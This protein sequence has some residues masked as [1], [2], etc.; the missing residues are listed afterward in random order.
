MLRFYGKV[1]QRT[2]TLLWESAKAWDTVAG[3]ATL[4]LLGLGVSVEW[5]PW[6]AVFAPIAL[7][8]FY[9]ALRANYEAFQ[10]I[11]RE[12][13]SLSKN[14]R[15]L[16]EDLRETRQR[17]E[18]QRRRANN[19]DRMEKLIDSIDTERKEIEA[20]CKQ[21]AEYITNSHISR[22]ALRKR[23]LVKEYV[24]IADLAL[25][26]AIVRGWTFEECEIYGPAIIATLGNTI[27]DNPTWI[28]NSMDDVIWEVS[29][30]RVDHIGVIGLD[31]CRFLDC[32]FVRVGYLTT[33]VAASRMKRELESGQDAEAED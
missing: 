16:I 13:D 17:E 33:P 7:L 27:I 10:T 22:E 32:T 24:Y 12:R 4:C 26:E 20:Q 18:E 21:T 8:F 9:G 2:P 15:R 3:V 28:A 19:A 6:W 25:K 23:Y 11:A 5:I 29:E 1:L 30:N 31:G 14:Y